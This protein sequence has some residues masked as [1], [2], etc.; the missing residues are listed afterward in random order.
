MIILVK[1]LLRFILYI[2]LYICVF[3][4]FWDVEIGEGRKGKGGRRSF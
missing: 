1:F 4:F 2:F 3:I